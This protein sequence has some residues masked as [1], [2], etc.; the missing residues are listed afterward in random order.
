MS[1]PAAPTGP[2]D[3]SALPATG[4]LFLIDVPGLP[5]AVRPLVVWLI[6]QRAFGAAELAAHTGRTAAEAGELLRVLTERALV[7][8]AGEGRWRPHLARRGRGTG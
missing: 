7:V 1:A 2:G 8:P 3:L 5:D 4:P 6:R